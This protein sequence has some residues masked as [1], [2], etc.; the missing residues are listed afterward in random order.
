MTIRVKRQHRRYGTAILL[1]KMI[2]SLV[3]LTQRIDPIGVNVS[4]CEN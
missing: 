4:M 1:V 3:M 2:S